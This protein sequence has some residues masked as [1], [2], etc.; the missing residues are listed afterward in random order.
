[1][2]EIDGLGNYLAPGFIDINNDSDHYLTLITRPSQRDFT[3]QGVTTTIGGH[4]GSS[5]AP[6]IYGSLESIRKWADPEEINVNWHSLADFL[7]TLEKLPL[8]VNFGTLVGYSTIRRALVGEVNRRLNL[9]ELA[10]AGR[11]LTQALQEGAFGL[12]TG[13]GYIHGRQASEKELSTLTKIVADFDGVYTTHLRS[14]TDE[15]VDSIKETI[16]IARASKVK[17]V[18]SHLRPIKGFED[19]FDE[20][21]KLLEKGAAK[22]SVYFDTSPSQTSVQAI[23]TLLPQSLQRKNLETMLEELEDTR[24]V[25][26][27][28][29][30]WQKPTARGM[31]VLSAPHH[32][33]LIGKIIRDADDFINL[34]VVTGLRATVLVP[35][36]NEEILASALLSSRA[37]IASSDISLTNTFPK[38]LEIVVKDGTTPIEQAIKKITADPANYFGIKKRGVIKERSIADMVIIGKSDYKVRQTILGGKVVGEEEVKGEILRHA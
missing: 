34:M 7:K 36:I 27:I 11:V 23:Y 6:L 20:A 31:R 16:K 5:L 18:I 2:K 13:L 21:L 1:K 12:S 4:C 26:L 22:A 19:Q 35:N 10:V 29:K 3:G 15:L 9:K 28:K 14:E 37:L 8:G 30:E 38:Y 33:Y 24:T 25:A 32:P 17:A